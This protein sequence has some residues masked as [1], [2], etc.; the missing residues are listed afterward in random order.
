M[1][2]REKTSGKHTYLQIVESHR[3][4]GKPRQ[5]V[6]ASLGRV[7]NLV[8]TGALDSLIRSACRFSQKTIA[9]AEKTRRSSDP[10]VRSR[11]FG[12]ATVFDRLW[13]RSGCQDVL[14]AALAGRRFTFDVERGISVL[15]RLFHDDSGADLRAH[16]WQREHRI[17]GVAEVPLYRA[18]LAASDVASALFSQQA[19]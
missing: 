11:A 2:V 1:F 4:D 7:E 13:R 18:V 9:L 10:N 5:S 19:P 6:V 12:P 16:C 15:H 17:E 8:A 3:R 14:R